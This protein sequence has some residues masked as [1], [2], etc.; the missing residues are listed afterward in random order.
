MKL[1]IKYMVSLRCKLMVKEELRK[2]E[3]N[4]A[5][6]DLG[7]V[8]LLENITPQQHD[9]LKEN[10]QKSGLDLLDDKRSILIRKNKK[11]DH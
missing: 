7:V 8:E 10:L 6:I 9:Q 11:C 2:L 3:I 5:K 4:Y 1:F